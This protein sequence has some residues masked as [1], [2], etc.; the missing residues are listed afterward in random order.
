MPLSTSYLIKKVP[1]E[2]GT[3]NEKLKLFISKPRM[4]GLDRF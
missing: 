1:T 3:K 2:A 4:L